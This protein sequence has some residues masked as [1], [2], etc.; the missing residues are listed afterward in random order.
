MAKP[1]VDQAALVAETVTAKPSN[2][3]LDLE[4]AE[5]AVD[6]ASL[7]V[8]LATTMVDQSCRRPYGSSQAG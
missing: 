7:M 3:T 5:A 4:T 6:E 2:A 1:I 8:Q